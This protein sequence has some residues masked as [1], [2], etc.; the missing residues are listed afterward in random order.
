MLF[1]LLA[2]V[3]SSSPIQSP[4]QTLSHL[5]SL[6][7][8]LKIIIIQKLTAA[9]SINEAIRD[10]KMLM[11]VNKKFYNII[12]DPQLTHWIINE[13]AQKY[14]AT[15]LSQI[16]HEGDD[17][18]HPA[19]QKNAQL[20]VAAV[21]LHTKASIQWLKNYLKDPEN[22]RIAEYLF[23]QMAR[24]NITCIDAL[25]NAGVNPNTQSKYPGFQLPYTTALE[26]AAINNYL[27]GVKR[28]LAAGADVNIT[29]SGFPIL[30]EA[31]QKKAHAAIIKALL[32]AGAGK[33][34]NTLTRAFYIAAARPGGR[35][36]I[37]TL[38]LLLNAGARIN[39]IYNMNG[40]WTA[41][42]AAIQI[43]KSPAVIHFLKSRG[44]KRASEL[45]KAK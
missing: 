26:A 10:I 35:F 36:A 9:H 1:F 30:E 2:F 27:E 31:V 20:I 33:D 7:K 8:D 14:A 34:I 41:L 29:S 39:D 40:G 4:N 11:R 22:M 19:M 18:R 16:P 13:I 23:V 12:N 21:S 6:L 43:G 45:Q 44:A 17:Q 42:D 37:P 38:T 24:D 28:L 15:I 25:L 32:D 3:F 5:D